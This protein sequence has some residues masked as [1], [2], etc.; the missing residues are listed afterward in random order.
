MKSQHC[1]RHT[2]LGF[3]R[4]ADPVLR[5]RLDRTGGEVA[6]RLSE[7]VP[8][9]RG[10]RADV[11]PP[12]APAISHGYARSI[13]KSQGATADQVFVYGGAGLDARLS[14]VSMTRHRRDV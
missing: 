14:Y 8:R 4:D 9:V 5:L 12:R 1:G 3:T 7:L 2:V 10:K 13:H 11:A 6:L